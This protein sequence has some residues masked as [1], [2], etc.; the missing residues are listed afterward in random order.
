M[1]IERILLTTDFSDCA[2]HAFGPAADLARRLGAQVDLAHVSEFPPPPGAEI[3]G[4]SIDDY[5]RRLL[6]RLEETGREPVFQGL[7]VA[8]R[9]LSGYGPDAVRRFQAERGHDLIVMATHG[10]SG[11]K[12]LLLGSFTEKVVRVADCPVLSVRGRN[13]DGAPLA[14]ERILYP[15]DF[16][17][18]SRSALE[19]VR[20]FAS[21]FGAEVHVFHVVFQEYLTVP[22]FPPEGALTP[23][24][25]VLWQEA[26]QR[27]RS[28]VESFAA[29]ELAGL[30]AST[31]VVVGRP[32]PSIVEKARELPA[33]LVILATH[34]RSGLGHALLGSVAERVVRK[35]PCSILTVRPRAA[36]G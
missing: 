29:R 35:A 7:E 4:V 23:E 10:H 28:E 21:L 19:P 27:A 25:A 24:L 3:I 36:G 31:D 32:V 30:P 6:A 8:P 33:D 13:G 34:G 11:L 20:F 5:N 14:V 9:L 16:S 18:L 22:S 17:E 26:E 15:Y 1:K 2:Q 12:H